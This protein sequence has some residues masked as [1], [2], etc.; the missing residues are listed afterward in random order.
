LAAI[1]QSP[2]VE[3]AEALLMLATASMVINDYPEAMRALT[4]ARSIY[5]GLSETSQVEAIDVVFNQL[6][7]RSN[8][9][10]SN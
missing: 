5:Q 10:C 8:Q 3:R 1:G 4:A 9:P 7:R 2:S 6:D